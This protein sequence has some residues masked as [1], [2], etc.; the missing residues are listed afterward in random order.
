MDVP[1][2][3]DNADLHDLLQ[4]F[5]QK[6]AMPD[7]MT[8]QNKFDNKLYRDLT[9]TLRQIKTPEELTLIRKAVE[10]FCQGQNEVMKVLHPNMSELDIQGL[11]EYIHKKYG[12]EEVGY[13]SIIGSG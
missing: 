6:T 9:G 7:Q 4:Q 13:V 8:R 12:A 10:I 2:R 3:F 11:H 5:R 1:N